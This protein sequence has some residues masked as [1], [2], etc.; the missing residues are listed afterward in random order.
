[1]L[2][3]YDPTKVIYNI[4]SPNENE[5]INEPK[6]TLPDVYE[7]TEFAFPFFQRLERAGR[8]GNGFN[9]FPGGFGRFGEQ[10]HRLREAAATQPIVTQ[11]M[12][13]FIPNREVTEKLKKYCGAKLYVRDLKRVGSQLERRIRVHFPSSARKNEMLGWYAHNWA[14]IEPVIEEFAINQ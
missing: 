12:S 13:D 10:I 8:F 14:A 6:V 3:N 4:Y 5:C 11:S 2:F 7:D 9:R 1:M